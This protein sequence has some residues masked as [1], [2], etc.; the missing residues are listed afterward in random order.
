M[1]NFSVFLIIPMQTGN[2][3][4]VESSGTTRGQRAEFV[5]PCLLGRPSGRCLKFYYFMYG[6]RM[7][8]L[9]VKLTLSDGR[10][11]YIFYKKGDQDQY[12]KKGIG[13]IDPAMV[14]R[15][16]YIPEILRPGSDA[17]LFLSRT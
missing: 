1:R 6:K 12:W 3:F 7:G 4:Y 15:G 16:R 11:W 5:T 2:Y 17:E 9:A 13:N 10:N 8:S 14:L